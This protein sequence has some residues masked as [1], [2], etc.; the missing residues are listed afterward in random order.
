MTEYGQTQT[1]TRP[2]IAKS[3]PVVDLPTHLRAV[4]STAADVVDSPVIAQRLDRL[5][6]PLNRQAI[7]E[8]AHLAGLWHDTGKAHPDWQRAAWI[9]AETGERATLPGHSARSAAYAYHALE[10]VSLPFTDRLSLDAETA[11]RYEV[12]LTNSIANHHTP[13][14]AGRMD[15]RDSRLYAPDDATGLGSNV[16][17]AAIEESDLDPALFPAVSIDVGGEELFEFLRYYD[18]ADWQDRKELGFVTQTIRGA[19]IQADHYVSAGE[20]GSEIARP[21]PLDPDSLA[22]FPPADRRPFQRRIDAL[23]QVRQVLGLAGCGEGK[24]HSSLQW[25]DRTLRAG[26]ADRI[27][28]AMPTRIT[29]NNLAMGLFGELDASDIGLYHGGSE[30]FIDSYSAESSAESGDANASGREQWDTSD[31]MLTEWARK[32]FQNPATVCTVDHVLRTLVNGYPHSKVARA[33]LLQSAVIFDELHAYDGRLLGNVL[34]AM[35]MLT[36]LGVPWYVM[37]ATLPSTVRDRLPE[38]EAV[39]S[40]GRLD[41]SADTPRRPFKPEV[42]DEGLSAE[43]AIALADATGSKRVMI[44]RNTVSSAN[45]TAARLRALGEDVTYYSSEIITE[46]RP[47]KEDEVRGRFGLGSYNDD[48]EGALPMRRFL[49]T[50]QICELSLDLSAD[51]LLSDIAP[52]DAILQ[53]AGRLHRAGTA[54]SAPACSCDQCSSPV[55]G[56]DHQ[57]RAIAFYPLDG[58]PAD[59]NADTDTDSDAEADDTEIGDST[60]ETGP[61]TKW[62][63]YATG[64]DT[65]MWEVLTRTATI[66]DQAEVYD[67]PSSIEWVDETYDVPGAFDIDTR[68]FGRAVRSDWLRGDARRFGDDS[69]GEDE[70]VI[71]DITTYRM[72][73]FAASYR[74]GDDD[75]ERTVEDLWNA[76][77]SASAGS[78]DPESDRVKGLLRS[79]KSQYS[80]G[81]P[82]WWFKDDETPVRQV[83][84]FPAG[85]EN[86]LPIVDIDYSYV[87]GLER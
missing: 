15:I 7:V 11:V 77:H 85:S 82:I 2:I 63:P 61:L 40:D 51:L 34:S 23:D 55:I 56:D 28:V 53:R 54:P 39:I 22:L 68:R 3:A 43:N 12:A 33:N 87:A 27:V 45:E 16:R 52:M 21:K 60:D 29:S 25:S 65:P 5:G 36:E 4:G 1:K 14:T 69:S 78:F 84:T 75:Q 66:L 38:H 86:G 70:L 50:T 24:T 31:P 19:L 30:H 59:E 17:R 47:T 62:L 71:R 80:V 44:V 49:V 58:S 46:D 9:S 32:W 42:I 74:C 79:F 26:I 10:S 41:M 76:E 13:L 48:G 8:L 18:H 20:Q 35:R 57:Y 73:A 72:P 64:R 67:F 37:T 6:S 81:V 83:G